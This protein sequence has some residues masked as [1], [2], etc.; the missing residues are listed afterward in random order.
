MATYVVAQGIGTSGT[1]SLGKMF[2][3]VTGGGGALTV[4]MGMYALCGAT[5]TYSSI[6]AASSSVFWLPHV[7]LHDKEACGCRIV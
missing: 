5:N 6:A 7:I 1:T 2:A 4:V 3:L